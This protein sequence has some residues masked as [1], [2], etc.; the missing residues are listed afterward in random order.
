MTGS[1]EVR[2]SIPLGS[3]S[4]DQPKWVG[5]FASTGFVRVRRAD[6]PFTALHTPWRASARRLA[7]RPRQWSRPPPWLFTLRGRHR[8]WGRTP[9]DKSQSPVFLCLHCEDFSRLRDVIGGSDPALAPVVV[10]GH[11]EPD[12]PRNQ[13]L[14]RALTAAGRRLIVCH[15]RATFPWCHLVLATKLL[16]APRSAKVVLVTEGG[17]RLVPW[18]KLL[19]C[20][21]GRRVLFDPFTSRYNTRVE[22]RQWFAPGTLQ[23]RIAHFQDWSSTRAADALLF[24]TE[25]HREYFFSR[26]GLRCSSAIVPVGVPEDLFVPSSVSRATSRDTEVLFYGTYIPLQ[27]IETI[28]DAAALVREES[29]RFSILGVGQTFEGIKQRVSTLNLDPSRVQLL[30]PV[31]FSTLPQR[32]EAADIV[33]GIFG[34]GTKASRVVPNKV[35]QAA[36][37]GRPIITADTPAIRRYFAH[38]ESAY[39]VPPGVPHELARALRELARDESLR[40][41]IGLGARAAFVKHFSQSVATH[42][43]AGVLQQLE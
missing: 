17:H 24:D 27:G 30:P 14:Q 37:L 7:V 35:V 21:T 15:S 29:F 10:L 9:R 4:K 1:H 6:G 41:R 12:Y 34:T 20:L 33:L 42:T 23:A 40:A 25:E 31:P 39:L 26:Y 22:D 43:L 3:T 18:V 16:R 38:C 8:R 32:L 19:S 28:V 11:H 2:G 36:A 5:L 13:A